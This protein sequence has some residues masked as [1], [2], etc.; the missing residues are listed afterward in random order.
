[1]NPIFVLDLEYRQ[2][3]DIKEIGIALIIETEDGKY[4]AAKPESNHLIRLG[5]SPKHSLFEA[6]EMIKNLGAEKCMWAS[7]GTNDRH[8][9]KKQTEDAMLAMPVGYFHIDIAPMYAALYGLD[10]PIRLKGAAE[11]ATGR[12]YGSQHHAEDDAWNAARV[13]A[14]L[15]NRYDRS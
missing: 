7:W 3:G 2:S 6:C 15:M 13:L 4:L 12:F 11:I 10:R 1:M 5:E 9:L 8:E 14:V